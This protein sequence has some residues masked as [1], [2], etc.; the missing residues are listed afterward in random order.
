MKA[1]AWLTMIAGILEVT[2]ILAILAL[3]LVPVSLIIYGL[4]FLRARE[5]VE[6]V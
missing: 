4:I 5:E 1:L 2:V 3:P 6:F